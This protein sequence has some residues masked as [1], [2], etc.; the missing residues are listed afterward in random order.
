MNPYFRY[1]AEMKNY[2][3]GIDFIKLLLIELKDEG[4]ISQLSSLY[5]EEE[6]ISILKE[7]ILTVQKNIK[8]L[9]KDLEEIQYP[10]KLS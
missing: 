9:L 3:K 6:S 10:N 8:D 4:K 1:R 5:S 2:L 7:T